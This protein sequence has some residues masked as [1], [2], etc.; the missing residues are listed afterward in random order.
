MNYED[1]NTRVE[2]CVA[3]C[4]AKVMKIAA[5]VREKLVVPLCKDDFDATMLAM[6]QFGIE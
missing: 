2:A 4:D 1:I 5:E 3:E 6:K